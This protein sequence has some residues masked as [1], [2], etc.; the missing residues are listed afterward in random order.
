[1]QV[2]SMKQLLKLVSE[3]S[4]TAEYTITHC[5]VNVTQNYKSISPNQLTSQL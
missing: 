4:I 1:M 5:I 2:E 3:F